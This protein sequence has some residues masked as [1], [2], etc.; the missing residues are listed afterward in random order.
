MAQK[1]D[2]FKTAPVEEAAPETPK[3]GKTPTIPIGKSLDIL[4]AASHLNKWLKELMEEQSTTIK[5]KM[6]AYF[7]QVGAEQHERP[8]NVKGLGLN[9]VA[10]ASLQMKVKAGSLTKQE[11]TLLQS[12]GINLH[13]VNIQEEEYVFN[14]AVL[15]N[16]DYRAKITAALGLID[17]HGQDPIIKRERQTAWAVDDQSFA[18]LFGKDRDTIKSLLPIMATMAIRPDFSGEMVDAL[19]ILEQNVAKKQ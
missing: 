3:K 19:N 16:P 6:E 2:I 4:A 10:S 12:A 8:V 13:E 17:F 7:A 15:A 5:K 9:K 14:K 18:D 11:E 1:S